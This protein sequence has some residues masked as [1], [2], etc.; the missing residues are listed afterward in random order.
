MNT[1]KSQFA[2]GDRIR[3]KPSTI[4]YNVPD[5]EV[6]VEKIPSHYPDATITRISGDSFDYEFDKLVSIHPRLGLSIKSGTCFKSG[7]DEWTILK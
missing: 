7:F 6:V 5:G 2:I 3:L 4:S 1:N